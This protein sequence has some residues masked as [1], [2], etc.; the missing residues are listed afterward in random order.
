MEPLVWPCRVVGD[1]GERRVAVALADRG[2][3][4]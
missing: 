3:V 4:E 2:D 1:E